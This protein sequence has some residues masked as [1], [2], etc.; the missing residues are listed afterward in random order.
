MTN[1]VL[2][3][4]TVKQNNIAD[5]QYYLPLLTRTTDFTADL[6]ATPQLRKLN[7]LLILARSSRRVSPK[8]RK[9]AYSAAP[10]AHSATTL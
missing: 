9:D 4:H 2:K 10:P 7:S 3:T 1:V 6:N 5:A 8:Q